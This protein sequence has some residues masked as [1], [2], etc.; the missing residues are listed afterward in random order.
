[1]QL[2]ESRYW[3]KVQITV[4]FKFGFLKL[5]FQHLH[6]LMSE[7][8]IMCRKLPAKLASRPQGQYLWSDF[9]L[10]AVWAIA[11]A[12]SLRSSRQFSVSDTSVSFSTNAAYVMSLT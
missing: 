7:N 6:L 11:F 5:H 1:M 10:V 12:F 9:A 4:R 8:M 3:S 2:N